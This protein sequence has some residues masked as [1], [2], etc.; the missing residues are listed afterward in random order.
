MEK[1]ILKSKIIAQLENKELQP[2]KGPPAG[3]ISRLIKETIDKN[4]IKPLDPET[5][6]RYMRYIPVWASV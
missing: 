5:A 6:K 1:N 3:S 4:K 2:L